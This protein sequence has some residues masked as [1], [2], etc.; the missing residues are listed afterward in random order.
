MLVG[1]RGR[2]AHLMEYLNARKVA[3]WL[4]QI[5]LAVE[6][7]TN[8]VASLQGHPLANRRIARILITDR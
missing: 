7:P 4:D 3:L 1:L 6:K 2:W 8:P 5:I